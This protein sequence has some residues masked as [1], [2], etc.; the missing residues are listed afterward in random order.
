MLSLAFGTPWCCQ[1]V[2]GP[3]QLL[4]NV[5][6]VL[7]HVV[8]ERGF[9][10]RVPHQQLQR[11]RLHP[12]RPARAVAL[13]SRAI[14]VGRL[15]PFVLGRQEVECILV[16]IEI[17]APGSLCGGPDGESVVACP[18]RAFEVVRRLVART[19]VQSVDELCRF[20]PA[21]SVGRYVRRT[22]A[23]AV[24]ASI[25]RTGRGTRDGNS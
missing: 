3:P 24:G 9:N 13:Q 7:R 12:G 21:H 22:R 15:E 18:L 2:H 6:R 16:A 14:P 1:R 4:G 11:G 17:R 5:G 20:V 25:V 10:A 23:P 8:F 19:R